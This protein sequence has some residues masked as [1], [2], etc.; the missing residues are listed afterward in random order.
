MPLII[1]QCTSIPTRIKKPIEIIF[2][3]CTLYYKGTWGTYTKNKRLL[4]VNF[5][6]LTSCFRNCRVHFSRTSQKNGTKHENPNPKSGSNLINFIYKR[7]HNTIRWPSR[8]KM[9]TRG[10]SV[11]QHDPIRCKPNWKS[12]GWFNRSHLSSAW[13][14]LNWRT[15]TRDNFIKDITRKTSKVWQGE[16]ILFLPFNYP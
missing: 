1:V 5:S 15:S 3:F 2:F 8:I 6:N 11:Q 13:L 4:K 12:I 14:Q 10:Y 16:Y 7:S 9:L